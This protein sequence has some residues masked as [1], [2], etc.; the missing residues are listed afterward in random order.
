LGFPIVKTGEGG[1]P[2]VV[3]HLIFIKLLS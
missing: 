1:A 3:T 2:G